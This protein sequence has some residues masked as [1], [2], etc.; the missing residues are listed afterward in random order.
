MWDYFS[1]EDQ[2][3]IGQQIGFAA[4]KHHWKLAKIAYN[5]KN[6]NAIIRSALDNNSEEFKKFAKMY[7]RFEMKN[8]K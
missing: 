2:N 7:K 4:R 1:K 5:D 8:K 6:A 3:L